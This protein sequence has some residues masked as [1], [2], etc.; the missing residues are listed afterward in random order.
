MTASG[1]TTVVAEDLGM[2]PDYVP[3]TLEKLG[4]PGF[5]IPSFFRDPDGNYEDPTEYPRLSLAQP[6]THDHPP[7]AAMWHE[8]WADIDA[9]GDV[10]KNRGDLEALMDFAGLKD[11][12]PPRGLDDRFHEGFTRAVMNSNSWLVVFQ[13]QDVFG[14]TARFNTPGSIA[15]TNWTQR[16][17]KTVKQL[18]HD[19]HLLAK[20]K[21]FSSLARR[22]GRTL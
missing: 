19:S 22:S 20:T 10:D 13:I 15:A 11:E 5:R 17:P 1:E 3:P 16:F 7:L 6:A 14:L 18:D 21:M 12:P 8:C 9:G 2:V 4:I